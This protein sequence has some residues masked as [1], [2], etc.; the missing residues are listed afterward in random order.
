MAGA[1][2]K[3]RKAVILGENDKDGDQ[4]LILDSWLKSMRKSPDGYL[5]DDLF[6]PTHR[7]MIMKMLD[8]CTVEVITPPDSPNFI[9]GYIV[10][11]K[12]VVHWVYVK[13]DYRNSGIAKSLIERAKDEKG[14]VVLTLTTPLGRKKLRWQIKPRELRFKLNKEF[15]R[16]R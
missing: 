8:T 4:I 3:I 7:L 9:L 13:K 1:E 14:D 5:P 12:G 16:G 11:D 2:L 10:Y 15:S 6:F